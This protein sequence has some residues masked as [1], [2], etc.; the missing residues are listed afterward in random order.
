MKSKEN[1]LS[2]WAVLIG[3][4][5][6][7]V[8]G[9][10]QKTILISMREWIYVLLAFL[11]VIIGLMSG[12][13]DSKDSITFLLATT[14]LVIVSSMGQERLILVGETGLLIVTILNA[15]VTMFIP[16]TII[17]AVKAVFSIASLK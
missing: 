11:G 8:L 13:E 7:V 16:A 4:V 3:V 9:I 15:L 2:A 17:V 14:S 12:R 6:A 10:F 1:L 5:V